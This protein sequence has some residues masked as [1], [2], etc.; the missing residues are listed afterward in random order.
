MLSDLIKSC[1]W[2]LSMYAREIFLNSDGEDFLRLK[3]FFT[4]PDFNYTGIGEIFGTLMLLTQRFFTVINSDTSK[5]GEQFERAFNLNSRNIKRVFLDV[6]NRFPKIDEQSFDKINRHIRKNLKLSSPKAGEIIEVVISV[7]GLILMMPWS[8]KKKAIVPTIDYGESQSRTIVEL[9]NTASDYQS[10]LFS[11]ENLLTLNPEELKEC[12]GGEIFNLILMNIGP[13]MHGFIVDHRVQNSES[14]KANLWIEEYLKWMI[15]L[16]PIYIYRRLKKEQVTT[17]LPIEIMKV[18]QVDGLTN[19]DILRQFLGEN[20]KAVADSYRYVNELISQVSKLRDNGVMEDLLHFLPLREK[21]NEMYAE[22]NIPMDVIIQARR[23]AR[24][25]VDNPTMSR[26]KKNKKIRKFE[27]KVAK[28]GNSIDKNLLN[29]TYKELLDIHVIQQ[30]ASPVSME[31]VRRDMPGAL[32]RSVRTIEKAVYPEYEY[33]LGQVFRDGSGLTKDPYVQR[34]DVSQMYAKLYEYSGLETIDVVAAMS[35]AMQ[36][37]ESTQIRPFL[38]SYEDDFTIQDRTFKENVNDK[39][40]IKKSAVIA[41]KSPVSSLISF[42][43]GLNMPEFGLLVTKPIVYEGRTSIFQNPDVWRFKMFID[44]LSSVQLSY[45]FDIIKVTP[46][47]TVADVDNFFKGFGATL[48]QQVNRMS[49]NPKP[50]ETDFPFEFLMKKQIIMRFVFAHVFM[51]KYNYQGDPKAKKI[52]FG[53]LDNSKSRTSVE[54]LTGATALN[55]CDLTMQSN[56]KVYV[57]V[58]QNPYLFKNISNIAYRDFFLRK[59]INNDYGFFNIFQSKAITRKRKNFAGFTE[60][61][62]GQFHEL[63]SS[64][65]Q[66]T[67]EFLVFVGSLEQNKNVGP[68]ILLQISKHGYDND[69][70]FLAMKSIQ[71]WVLS[72]NNLNVLIRTLSTVGNLDNVKID[73]KLAHTDAEIQATKYQNYVTRVVSKLYKLLL[74][75]F[76]WSNLN[77]RNIADYV[78]LFRILISDNS[79]QSGNLFNRNNISIDT[80]TFLSLLL[81][82]RNPYNDADVETLKFGQL[83]GIALGKQNFEFELSAYHTLQ[84][85]VTMNILYAYTILST[86]TQGVERRYAVFKNIFSE[87]FPNIL[88][89]FQ[90]LITNPSSKFN[91]VLVM[92]D[93]ISSKKRQMLYI[94]TKLKL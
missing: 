89:Y 11:F 34:I 69:Y 77:E 63:L 31:V 32:L 94:L 70:I 62:I 65:L 92:D 9:F 64:L 72:F 93:K 36:L 75:M 56:I 13:L 16:D 60:F 5:T 73:A 12:A 24:K 27:S 4:N 85:T 53:S 48:I 6:G 2:M 18:I 22:N 80:R 15:F 28:L 49:M 86:S 88:E 7:V 42:F 45:A 43:L 83:T 30:T 82:Y 14:T 25:Q 40:K 71:K 84:K 52:L 78:K 87:I 81:R 91:R 38:E 57:P 54:L 61:Q 59:G 66:D 55:L 50:Q 26:E 8:S 23:S 47:N 39:Y 79:E 46:F 17:N 90:S 33:N 67:S 58:S 44:Q 35:R 3:A 74:K 1:I 29:N 21:L 20:Y 10:Q 37:L 68:E 41:S 19:E 76:D 51:I